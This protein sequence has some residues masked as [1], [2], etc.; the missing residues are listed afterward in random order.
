MNLMEY[1]KKTI[2]PFSSPRN[3]EELPDGRGAITIT[4]LV[5]NIAPENLACEHGLS[6]W[7]EHGDRQILFDTGQ[8]DIVVKNAKLLGIELVGTD[9]IVISHGHY[10]HT[11]GLNAVLDIALK[12]TLYIHPEALGEKFSRRGENIRAIGISDSDKETIHTLA[13]R[14]RIVWTEKPTEIF[15]GLFATGKIPRKT[16]IEDTGGNFFTSE[17]C[18]KEDSLLDDQAIFAETREGVV[19]ILG[20]AHSG[21][22]NTLNYVAKLTNQN[23]IFAVI[24]GMHLLSAS[25][26]RIERTI[27]TFRRYDV[28]KIAPA[29]CTGSKA[30]AK[31]KEAFG[32]RCSVC[33]VGSRM[34]L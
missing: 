22:I 16:N 15:P 21:V 33:C 17:K 7:I 25:L 14:G 4:T 24:G 1:A 20:C 19:V 6:F 34:H 29:N 28:Q 18:T 2:K 13:G 8:S 3:V 5:D 26:Q 30:V 27:D 23:H 9:A 32:E 12:A 11:G 10:D 31:F